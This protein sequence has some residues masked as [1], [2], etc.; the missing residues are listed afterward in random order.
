MIKS[1]LTRMK[2]VKD[3][4]GEIETVDVTIATATNEDSGGN[5]DTAR[6]YNEAFKV[7]KPKPPAIEVDV[8]VRNRDIISR[9]WIEVCLCCVVMKLLKSGIWRNNSNQ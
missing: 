9:F 5:D 6:V 4:A 8:P 3:D 1:N 7:V 2:Q